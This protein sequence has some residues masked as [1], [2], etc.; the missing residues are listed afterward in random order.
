MQSK[1]W[2]SGTDPYSPR[3]LLRLWP[4]DAVHLDFLAR[5]AAAGTMASKDGVPSPYPMTCFV[6][7]SPFSR[8]SWSSIHLALLATNFVCTLLLIGGLVSLAGLSRSD[9]H[10]YIFWGLALGL[11]PLHT[12]IAG[13]NLIVIVS[14]CAVMAMW[15]AKRGH[16]IAAGTL[17][18]VAACLKPTVG[19]VFLAYFFLS[20]RWLTAL[21][22]AGFTTMVA[23]AAVLRYG[24]T[25]PPW[26][27]SYVADIKEM[28]GP[29]GINDFRAANS[30][31][32]HLLNLQ[33]PA[34]AVVGDSY[35]A[36]AIAWSVT[37]ILILWWIVL[38]VQRS[39]GQDLLDLS[40]IA[41]IALLPVYHRFVDAVVLVLP[42]CWCLKAR[43]PKHKQVAW[44]IIL[45]V[46]PFLIPGASLL[47]TVADSGHVSRHVMSS[48]WWNAAVMPHEVWAVLAT[49][50]A[51][52]YA[53]SLARQ[54]VSEPEPI[55]RDWLRYALSILRPPAA[56]VCQEAYSSSTET[57][58]PSVFP[59]AL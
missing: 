43:E 38:F 5:D 45:L 40:A 39:D 10:T 20:R 51:L 23:A 54:G 19:L 9:P 47:A 4:K 59:P 18:G 11:A 33:M 16:E 46:L 55:G 14:A 25:V 56:E 49:S 53:M 31:R 15:S 6:L 32:F 21:T 58:S 57:R 24:L 13:G 28:F 30:L 26:V 29:G 36:N 27:S 12:A 35:A 1:A 48:V 8:A 34:Y 50:L 7:L 17:L 42:L 41:T 2:V 44:V 37:G 22:G 3:E 52:L